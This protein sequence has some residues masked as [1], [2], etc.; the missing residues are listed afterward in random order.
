MATYVSL[1]SMTDR[2]EAEI[3]KTVDRAN[4]FREDA[5]SLGASVREIYWTIGGF[6][7]VVVFDAPDDET[8]TALMLGLGSKGS[9]QTQTLRAFNSDEIKSIID[10]MA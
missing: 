9:V 1:I 8:A 10:R 2:G 7:G 5:N 6:D 4:T 3:K